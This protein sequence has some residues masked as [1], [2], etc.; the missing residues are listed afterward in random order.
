MLV[1]MMREVIAM[2]LR[3]M[4]DATRHHQ[5]SPLSRCFESAGQISS[6]LRHRKQRVK[7]RRTLFKA[8][9][10]KKLLNFFLILLTALYRMSPR[11]DLV[12]TL[13]Q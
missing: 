6:L 10:G 12:K 4:T 3:L 7:V 13:P 11:T 8:N 1:V 2:M 9:S 5:G